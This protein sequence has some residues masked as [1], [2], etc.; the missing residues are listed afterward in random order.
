MD[1][2]EKDELKIEDISVDKSSLKPISLKDQILSLAQNTKVKKER[3]NAI[4]L[5]DELEGMSKENEELRLDEIEVGKITTSKENLEK[6]NHED[7]REE[8]D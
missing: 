3:N 2:A 8:R 6:N 1:S 7:D 4:S 5:L